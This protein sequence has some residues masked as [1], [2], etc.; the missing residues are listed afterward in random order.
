MKKD[1]DVFGVGDVILEILVETGEKELNDL[2]TSPGRRSSIS[3]EER[4]RILNNLIGHRQ[5]LKIS[6]YTLTVF[7]VLSCLGIKPAMSTKIGMDEFGMI[8]QKELS[9]ARIKMDFNTGFGSTDSCLSIRTGKTTS[10]LRHKG[11]SSNISFKEVDVISL[12]KSDAVFLDGNLLS[13]RNRI[14]VARFI[15]RI[16][17]ESGCKI[18]FDTYNVENITN[19]KESF[20]ELMKESDVIISSY[21]EA[22][23]LLDLSDRNKILKKMSEFGRTIILKE[24]KQYTIVHD[25]KI[26]SVERLAWNKQYSNQYFAAGFI[27]GFLGGY[28]IQKT[29][30]IASYLSGKEFI[31]DSIL[32]ELHKIL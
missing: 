17:K 6:G 13:S 25:G 12:K 31:D 8:T 15:T 2:G 5:G 10:R 22:F 23:L 26:F 1:V 11:I 24:R 4:D 21:D 27:F 3:L 19:N 32:D 20:I 18:I 14:R 30:I 28:D 29:G 9:K 7:K 16:A